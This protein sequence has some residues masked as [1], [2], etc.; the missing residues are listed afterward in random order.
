MSH[1]RRSKPSGGYEVLDYSKLYL[2]DPRGAETGAGVFRVK[3]DHGNGSF[4]RYCAGVLM[5]RRSGISF[6]AADN[7]D[8]LDGCQ[9]VKWGQPRL[10]APHSGK[11]QTTFP[12]A[13]SLAVG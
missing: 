13:C 3:H 10:A 5:I 4:E 9:P 7:S 6:A 1:R 8:R 2:G 11:P 12:V